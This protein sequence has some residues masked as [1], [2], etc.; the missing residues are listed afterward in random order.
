EAAAQTPYEHSYL[1]N[2]LC[3]AQQGEMLEALGTVL[4]RLDIASPNAEL[5][6]LMGALMYRGHSFAGLEW[7]DRFQRPLMDAAA[8]LKGTDREA[9]VEAGRRTR[10]FYQG[11]SNYGVSLTLRDALERRKLD[12]VRATDMLE[13]VYANSGRG[14]RGHVR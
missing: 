9:F 8:G 5:A 6:Y 1:L 2:I 13:S 14:G 3:R 7:P 10:D 11:P 4:D 12:C